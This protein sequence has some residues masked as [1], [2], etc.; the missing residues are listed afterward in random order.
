[1]I[2][3]DP[4]SR[5]VQ[6]PRMAFAQSRGRHDSTSILFLSSPVLTFFFFCHDLSG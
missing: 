6:N 1:M 2:T 5:L 4:R 3:S